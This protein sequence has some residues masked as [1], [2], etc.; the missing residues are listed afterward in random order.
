MEEPLPYTV[1]HGISA[2]DF[3]VSHAQLQTWQFDTF[4]LKRYQGTNNISTE[5]FFS[6][7]F[8]L[9]TSL[10]IFFF[11]LTSP[12]PRFE[13]GLRTARIRSSR[14]SYWEGNDYRDSRKPPLLW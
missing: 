6:Q 7:S 3:L 1:V 14:A 2:E 9:K 8:L 10:G 11:K 13:T 4:V 12:F 5:A